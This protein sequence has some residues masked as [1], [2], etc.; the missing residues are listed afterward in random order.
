MVGRTRED[1]EIRVYESDVFFTRNGLLNGAQETTLQ[2]YS[3]DAKNV[4]LCVMDFHL[5]DPE[6]ERILAEAQRQI[7]LGVRYPVLELFGTLWAYLTR[8]FRRR[9]PLDLRR[10]SYCSAFINDCYAVVE[11]IV[12]PSV[13]HA[14]NVSPEYLFQSTFRNPE[15]WEL[16]L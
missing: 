13:A 1:G 9:N 4:L 11:R 14:T 10:A 8:S 5:T 15:R 7:A 6:V 16:R 12:P 2:K 3:E